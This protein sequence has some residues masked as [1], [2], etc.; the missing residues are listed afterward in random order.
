MTATHLLSSLSSLSDAGG[1][2]G[3]FELH[4][5]V[6]PLDPVAQGSFVSLCDQLGVKPVLIHAPG[7]RM[8][9]QPMTFSYLEGDIRRVAEETRGLLERLS[10]GGFPA[11]RC[12]LEA[13]L[14]ARGVPET[15][16]DAAAHPGRYF[17]F[18]GKVVLGA[19]PEVE[20]LRLRCLALGA[21]L[22]S[23]AFRTRPDAL[24]E[25]FVTLRAH[26][27]GRATALA[28]FRALLGA[29]RSGGYP[30]GHLLHEYSV[31]DTN[32]L[33]DH[34]W[35]ALPSRRLTPPLRRGSSRELPQ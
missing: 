10:S 1:F 22:S 23:N 21:H 8:A 13:T 24:Q 3:T 15:D 7:A 4:L 14:G 9:L 32:S 30:A 20:A 16:L 5:T 2:S 19:D 31:L 25:R 17:E 33:L 27:V 28:R 29:L 11:L 18:H 26:R 34:G 6:A 35:L 12:K